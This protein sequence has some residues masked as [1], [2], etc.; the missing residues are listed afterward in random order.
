VGPHELHVGVVG[1]FTPAKKA[2]VAFR[3]DTPHQLLALAEKLDEQNYPTTWNDGL[4]GI[5]RFFTT[6][7]WGNRLEFLTDGP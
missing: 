4:P 7:P 3:L 6:D 2:H 5:Q 1:Q